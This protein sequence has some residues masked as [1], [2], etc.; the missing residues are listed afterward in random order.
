VAS[1]RDLDVSIGGNERPRK[2]SVLIARAADEV[3][4]GNVWV[5]EGTG[6]DAFSLLTEMA[7]ATE[8]VGL[9]TGIVNVFSRTPTAL[10]QATATVMEVM[11]GRHFNLGLGTSGKALMQQYHGV[12]FDR[13]VTRLREAVRII[14]EAFTTG[15]LPHGGDVFDLG[16]LQVGV[17]VSRER[18]RIYVAGLSPKTLELTGRYA[19]GWLPI[20]P[21]ATRGQEPL[22]AVESAARSADRKPP[23]VSGY[24]YGG[25]GGREVEQHVRATLA[26]YVAANGTA[27]R[28]LFERYGYGEEVKRICD[29]WDAGDREAARRS[30]D[31]KLLRD[32]TLLGEPDEFFRSL[33]RFIDAGIDR[34]VL[35]LPKQ[36]STAQCLEMLARL[37]QEAA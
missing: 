9:G 27:Y 24:L 4:I 5:T 1:M 29:L 28:G 25:V 23:V 20:W 18:L 12:P 35:R 6:R 22:H 16:G 21:S 10:V 36:F 32:T 33:Q 3:G 17:P 37:A 2:E 15:Q 7:L 34:P 26:W 11:E 19:D 14:D 30:V 31:D 13:P 8:R